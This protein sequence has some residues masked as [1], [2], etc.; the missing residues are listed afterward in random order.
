MK[1]SSVKGYCANRT[2][3]VPLNLIEMAILNMCLG[4][5]RKSALSFIKPSMKVF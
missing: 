2:G 1:I 5:R 4:Y 3:N